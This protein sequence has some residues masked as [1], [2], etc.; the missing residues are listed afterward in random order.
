MVV[1]GGSDGGPLNNGALYDPPGWHT[2]TVLAA[3][4]PDDGQFTVPPDVT[5]KL[6][7]GDE[8]RIRVLH[9]D[10]LAYDDSDADMTVA[11]V[12]V[13]SPAGGETLYVGD[14]VD[15]RWQQTYAA[16]T[17]SL[18]YSTS[19]VGGPWT[20]FQGALAA[21]SNSFPWTP[22]VAAAGA[23]VRVRVISDQDATLYA[24]SEPFTV[25]GISITAPVG[26]ESWEPASAQTITWSSVG[27]ADVKIELS[28]DNGA[29]WETISPTTP[30]SAGSLGWPPT[31]PCSSECLVRITDLL[32]SNATA[33]S[34]V[35]FTIPQFSD[36]GVGITGVEQG[37]SVAWGDYDSNGELD[38]AVMGHDGA[39]GV[40]T[41][42]I[43]S[44][45]AFVPGPAFTGVWNGTLAW[46]DYDNDGD[47]DLTATGD[48]GGSTPSST[49]YN[50]DG[51]GL[52]AIPAGLLDVYG[53]GVAWGDYDNDGDLDLA[54]A[55]NDTA[56][57][58]D[59]KI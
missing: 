5:A 6:S 39:A 45:G 59:T 46:G 7:V 35:T 57:P 31:T 23:N 52:S 47:L 36:A 34:P 54:V 18:A 43:N 27:V 29:T 42:Y 30:A 4:T 14:S 32:D 53:S 49:I 48:L 15:I 51:V 20:T 55:G 13:F 22:T 9:L 50:N 38:L 56:A 11:Q 2:Q 19:G 17:V 24:L 16:T 12:D 10:S 1:W 41:V 3:S 28:R 21:N 26:G 37:A 40:G 25:K 8:Y 33:T 44:A 58:Y